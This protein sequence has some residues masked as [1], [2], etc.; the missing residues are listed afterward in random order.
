MKA[1]PIEFWAF[2]FAHT[3][4]SFAYRLE[5]PTSG[6]SLVVYT[7]QLCVQLYMGG[8]LD[9]LDKNHVG[10]DGNPIQK[11]SGVCLETQIHPDAINQ[12]H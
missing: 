10:L 5:E 2:I 3:Y 6:T 8:Y 12:V 7:N 4:P 1:P 9:L 11:Y